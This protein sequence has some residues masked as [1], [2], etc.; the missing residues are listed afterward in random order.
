[1]RTPPLLLNSTQRGVGRERVQLPQER[2]VTMLALT[3]LIFFTTCGGAFG[4]E[5]L[6]GAVGPGWAIVLILVT[7]FVWSLPTALMVAELA[8]LMPDEGGYYVWIRETFGPF[9]AVQQAC[10]T[11]TCSVV[12]LA[13]FPVL[14]VSYL[15]FFIPALATSENSPHFGIGALIRWLIAILVIASGMGLNLRGA[16]EVGSSAKV[17]AYFVLGAFVLLLLVWLK[18]GLAPSSVADVISRDLSSSH[19]GVLLLG[20]SYIVFN[21]SGWENASTYAGEVDRPQRN[22]PRALALALVVLVLCYLIPVIAG[23]TVTSDPA[24]WSSDAGWPVISQLIGGRWLGRLVA[25]AGLVSMW[26]LFNAQLLYVSRLPYVLACD[27]WLPSALSRVSPSTAVPRIAIFCFGAIAAFFAALSFGSLAIIQCL[28]YAGALTLEFLA[29]IVLRIRCPHADRSFRVP[30]G[31]LGMAYVC[32]SPFA[33][34]AVLVFGALRDWRSYPG[35]L[36]VIGVVVVIGVA[37]YFVRRGV[38]VTRSSESFESVSSS[39]PIVS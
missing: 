2:R 16:H 11:M 25:A 3:C 13:M 24:I 32:L 28:L 7:P 37:L 5:P 22:Y 30:G 23:V 1:V 9:W 33:F 12:W 21:C 17:S 6:I 29:L 4:L 39:R 31:W 18:V 36:F 20:L 38:A 27:G 19:K 15:A 35:Q 34:A 10:W 26:G 14:F 8:T